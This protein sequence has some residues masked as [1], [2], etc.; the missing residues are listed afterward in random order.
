MFSKIKKAF[1]TTT[2]EPVHSDDR[3]RLYIEIERLRK[4]N[5]ELRLQQQ[6]QRKRESESSHPHQFHLEFFLY[7]ATNQKNAQ[8]TPKDVHRY[9]MMGFTI[10][11]LDE[12]GA[13]AC[14]WLTYLL[15]GLENTFAAMKVVSHRVEEPQLYSQF[16]DIKLYPHIEVKK[17]I[18]LV[19]QQLYQW[20][21][22]GHDEIS[23]RVHIG[24][25]EL[26]QELLNTHMEAV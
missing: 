8:Y 13:E 6:L 4:E 10:H 5:D 21:E 2:S 9:P 14:P 12:N 11:F 7:D 25:D 1:D 23:L 3:E 20:Q 18:Y 22:Q 16:V 19:F 17:C 15:R 24:G 26:Y